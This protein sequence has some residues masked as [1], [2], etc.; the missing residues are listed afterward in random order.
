MQMDRC[1]HPHWQPRHEQVL[2]WFLRNPSG[3][4]YD[5]AKA[6]GYTPSQ[7]SRIVN[8][9]DFKLRYESACEHGR[10]DAFLLGLSGFRKVD[11]ER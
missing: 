4:Q 11:K 10:R 9:P 1:P 3:R 6:T 7:I 5:C 2:L 8:S